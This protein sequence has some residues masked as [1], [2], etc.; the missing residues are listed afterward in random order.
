MECDHMKM[1]IRKD[2]QTQYKGGMWHPHK[3]T[4]KDREKERESK[5]QL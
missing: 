4:V 5:I 2:D 1:R 3:E